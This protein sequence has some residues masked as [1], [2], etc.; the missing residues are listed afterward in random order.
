MSTIAVTNVKHPSAVDPA[1]VLD[2]SGDVTYAGVH[3][4]SA[5]TVTGAPQG[6]VHIATES[7]SAVSTVSLN[8]VFTSTY[9]NYL[10]FMDCSNISIGADMQLRFRAAG[11]DTTTNTYFYALSRDRTAPSAGQSF[12]SGNPV[13]QARLIAAGSGFR[14]GLQLHFINPLVSG[15]ANF[16][17]MVNTYDSGYIRANV[18]GGTTQAT[19]H[20]GLSLIRASG[21]MTGVI[22]VYG[23]QNS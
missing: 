8:D 11:S 10:L 15:N 13:T 18:F 12:D 2:A 14:F 9:D 4:F 16:R 5:A 17:G 20:D 21:N 23:Y 6:L 22:R 7:F 3:D 19:A 1:L